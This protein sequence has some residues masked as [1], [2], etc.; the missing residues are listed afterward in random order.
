M[1][2]LSLVTLG[3]AL[4][5]LAATGAGG[6]DGVTLDVRFKLTDLDYK[7]LPGAA[8]RVVFG[9]DVD[10]QGPTSGYRFVTDAN[11]EHRFATRVRLDKRLRKVPTNFIGSLLS[12]PQNTDH[13]TVAAELEYM[14]FRWLYAVDVCRFS[15]GDVM[16]DGFTVYSAGAGGRFT[17]QAVHDENGWRMADLEGRVLTMPG[18]EAWDFMLQPDPD[19]P[20]RR[21][22]TLQLAFKRAPP[23]V[24]R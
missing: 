1:T 24:W 9:S 21:H 7:P 20:A 6:G 16:L 4:G 3:T 2:L 18:Y 23:P 12:I 10:W 8:V 22:W 11:G 17:N 5:A 14:S 13:L 15:S 19:D